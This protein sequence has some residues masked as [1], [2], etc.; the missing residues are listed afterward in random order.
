MSLHDLACKGG[1]RKVLHTINFKSWFDLEEI[2]L[3]FYFLK[4]SLYYVFYIVV[5]YNF[6]I[7]CCINSFRYFDS[8]YCF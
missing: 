5:L 1:D 3:D 6:N 4:S 7:Y 8:T 2:F